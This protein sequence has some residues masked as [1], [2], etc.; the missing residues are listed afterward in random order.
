M[1]GTVVRSTNRWTAATLT[2]SGVVGPYA[3]ANTQ[4]AQPSEVSRLV[5]MHRVWWQGDLGADYR[6]QNVSVCHH[7]L[8]NDGQFQV[9][10]ADNANMTHP[11]IIYDS[12]LTD[13]WGAVFPASSP[14]GDGSQK[15]NAD[16]KK[17]LPGAVWVHDLSSEVFGRYVQI[18]ADD[19]NNTDG[20]IEASY[21]NV[22]KIKSP[23]VYYP[24]R[25]IP[26]EESI[27]QVSRTGQEWSKGFLKRYRAI[28]DY[29]GQSE[30]NANF[31]VFLMNEIG[32][33]GEF[34]VTVYDGQTLWNA[35]TTMLCQFASDPTVQ[36][37][38]D[39]G[40]YTAVYLAHVE[41]LEVAG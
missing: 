29:T 13:A 25:I 3:I 22:S 8:S 14:F 28:A 24:F 38:E 17:L 9:I 31:W 2:S 5:G 27:I 4:N 23:D 35:E 33:S 30:A 6:I 18:L 12:G 7:N 40:D 26:D 21:I 39:S 20:Y 19:P 32:L 10:V 16:G 34:I 11:T 41:L 15:P 1:P 36:H 37:Q